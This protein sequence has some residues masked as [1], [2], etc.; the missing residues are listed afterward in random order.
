MEGWFIALS[1]VAIVG[2]IVALEIFAFLSAMRYGQ[3]VSMADIERA[4]GEIK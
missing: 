2:L 4:K 3:G 1:I